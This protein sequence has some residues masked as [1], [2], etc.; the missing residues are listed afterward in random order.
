[1]KG[2]ACLDMYSF[3]EIFQALGGI[4]LLFV[5]IYIYYKY[6][7]TILGVD[8]STSRKVCV[9][10]RPIFTQKMP[11]PIFVLQPSFSKSFQST[12]HSADG[13]K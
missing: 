2:P 13:H 11:C 4:D 8:T 9:T 1:M 7:T 5:Y 3:A 12:C 6:L 10:L